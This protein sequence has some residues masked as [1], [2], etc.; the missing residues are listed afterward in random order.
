M[1]RLAELI[2]LAALGV[3][4]WWTLLFLSQ[5]ALM[6]PAP[7][8]PRFAGRPADVQV[9]WLPT[10][11]GRVEAW[12]LPPTDAGSRPAPLLLFAHGNGELIDYLPG[13]F[14]EP[15]AWGAAVLLVEYPGYGRSE[16]RP[17][18]ERIAEVMRAAWDWAVQQPAVDPARVV[19][20]GRSV[21]AGAACTL[22]GERPIAGLILESAFTSARSFARRYGAPGFLVR[23]PFDNVARLQ[24][25]KGPLLIVHGEQDRVIPIRHGRTL[26]ATAPHAEY[27]ELPCGHND[28]PPPLQLV[29][30]FLAKHELIA[31]ER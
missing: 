19:A 26:A 18:Q 20:W 10:S 9:M 15:R 28:C 21:G 3:G 14:D 24:S 2:G 13:L 29:R 16:G 4:A 23:D 27:H 17:S 8:V 31:I 30:A 7:P 25:Y 11:A 22:V 5:R 12:F 1:V 6:Y